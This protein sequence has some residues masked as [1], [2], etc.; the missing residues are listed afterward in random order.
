MRFLTQ[1]CANCPFRKDQHFMLRVERVQEIEGHLRGDGLF[2]CHKEV[3]RVNRQLAAAGACAQ[4]EEEDEDCGSRPYSP[5]G[6]VPA[7]YRSK[8]EPA[9]VCGGALRWMDKHDLL[10]AN[11]ATRMAGRLGLFEW[12][13]PPT[14]AEVCDDIMHLACTPDQTPEQLREELDLWDE[15]ED[16]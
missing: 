6:V 11:R 9:G 12:P 4:N 14:A 7:A 16:Y 2:H 15:E 1:P 3:D 10:Y 8:V 5:D 13:L